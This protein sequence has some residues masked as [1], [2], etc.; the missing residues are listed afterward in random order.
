[1]Q[2]STLFV[3]AFA[4]LAGRHATSGE[5]GGKKW[6]T[7]AKPGEA[8]SPGAHYDLKTMK[9]RLLVLTLAL[10]VVA[11]F[12]VA[13][14]QSKRSRAAKEFMRDKLDLSQRVLEGLATE[15]YDL[16]SK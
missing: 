15:D 1:M 12:P 9:T 6:P 5:A 10:A 14:A 4:F 8:L 16:K 7:L 2:H 13:F 3:E 11:T